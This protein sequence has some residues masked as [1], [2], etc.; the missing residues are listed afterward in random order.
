MVRVNAREAVISNA[1]YKRT[2]FNLVG[3]AHFSPKTAGRVRA[4]VPSPGLA[5]LFLGIERDLAAEGHLATNYWVYPSY[6]I[7]AAYRA[8]SEGR[9]LDS[10]FAYV[11]IASL[12]TPGNRRLAPP[13]VTNLQVMTVAPSQPEAW[14]VTAAQLADGSDRREP[15]YRARKAE[16][17]GRLIDALEVVVP[18]ARDGV[19][20]SELA[21]PLTQE[22]YTAST[23]GTSYGLEWSP[24]QLPGARAAIKSE[25]PGLIFCGANTISHGIVGVMISGLLASSV[26]LGRRFAGQVLSGR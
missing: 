12:R 3:E 1:D 8:A 22:R 2:V 24:Q 7:E 25:I 19:V 20:F 13:G 18:K 17:T 16:M 26:L 15:A 5:V 4:A 9:F 23:G 21:T 6:E 14:G 10:T 11:S